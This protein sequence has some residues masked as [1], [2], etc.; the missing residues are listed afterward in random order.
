MINTYVHTQIHTN[1]HTNLHSEK[2]R[3]WVGIK[4]NWQTR[5]QGKRAGA[6]GWSGH[7][8][9]APL[10]ITN[11]CLVHQRG[12]AS[13]EHAAAGEHEHAVFL[14][15]RLERLSTPFAGGANAVRR[16]GRKKKRIREERRFL[17][18][19]PGVLSQL[20]LLITYSILYGPP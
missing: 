18:G 4:F 15:E 7:A 6:S 2:R 11:A 13:C 3:S 14:A 12:L 19:G 10:Q 8:G 17:R 20:H 5:P 16:G 1:I 9:G